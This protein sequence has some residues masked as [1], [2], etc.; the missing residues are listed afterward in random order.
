MKISTKGRYAIR[1]MADLAK[2]GRD[3]FISLKAVSARQNI[4]AKYA[5]Q[6][7]S[8]LYKAG[9]VRSSRGPQG[10]Y[11][12]AVD[13]SKLSVG[14]I[15]RVAEGS[16]APV[17]CLEDEE[18]PCMHAEECITVDFWDNL[19]KLINDYVDGVTLEDICKQ[20]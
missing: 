20:E 11:K 1:I 15:L 10:G 14:D 3:D 17:A 18:N 6:I 8:I 13:A 9:L 4:S 7:I 16:L 19:Y 5:E 2:N 12:L